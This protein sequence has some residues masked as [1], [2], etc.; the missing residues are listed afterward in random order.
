[1]CK[2]IV[3]LLVCMLLVLI[4]PL[5]SLA[6]SGG[7]NQSEYDKL[8]TYEAKSAYLVEVDKYYASK[9]YNVS[10]DEFAAYTAACSALSDSSPSATT[11]APDN[12][13]KTIA[14][15]E[16][17]YGIKIV[18][19]NNGAYDKKAPLTQHLLNIERGLSYLGGTFTKKLAKQ[20]EAS[21]AD[22]LV[23][24]SR[25]DITGKFRINLK[26]S[27]DADAVA[28]DR[29]GVILPATARYIYGGG[30]MELYGNE[31]NPVRV[32]SIVHEYAHALDD[33]VRAGKNHPAPFSNEKY[34]MAGGAANIASKSPDRFMNT[35][36]ETK[37]S[38]DY[39]E[40]FYAA[41][42]G[43]ADK[44][45]AYGS[46]TVI[47]KKVKVVYDDLVTFA[48]VDSRATQRVGGYLGL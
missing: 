3:W 15:L 13:A 42:I 16:K 14:N 1:M 37:A 46:D 38:E 18:L 43:G 39:A 47:W 17:T 40:C 20:Y 8:K 19:G 27:T 34:T 5:T 9:N 48:G 26:P 21:V 10:A 30:V 12:D 29:P 32:S 11:K 4:L 22:K 24:D 45:L 28:A 36:A 2:R 41:I 23:T 6:T 25:P 33:A 7:F 35:Y 44:P 31:S